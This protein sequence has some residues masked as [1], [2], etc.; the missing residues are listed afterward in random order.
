[1]KNDK[2]TV[3]LPLLIITV[4]IGW[5]LMV[6]GLIPEINWVW[7]LALAMLGVG[8][9]A[10]A[11]Y[12]KFSVVVGTFFI[13]SSLFSV[14]RQ[15]GRIS[16]DMEVPLLIITLGALLLVARYPAIP[17]PEWVEQPTGEKPRSGSGVRLN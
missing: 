13:V 6:Q 17:I 16:F 1:M 2:I 15:T 14:L 9:Y 5:L 8:T 11:G 7:T 12:N 4:G 10:G 3:L